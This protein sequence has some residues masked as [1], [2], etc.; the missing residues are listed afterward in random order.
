MK[1]NYVNKTFSALLFMGLIFTT[2][3]RA[4]TLGVG[5]IA[6]DWTLST[7]AGE[8]VNYY[9]DSEERV[10]VILFWATW[11][12]YCRSLMPHLKIL[13]ELYRSK[14]V[15][16]Y[17]LNFREDSD[18]VA[19]FEQNK[20]RFKLMLTADLVAED[21]GVKG[22]PWLL[23]IDKNKKVIYKRPAGITDIIVSQNVKYAIK[24]ALTK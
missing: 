6:P 23:V 10:S 15:E 1:D 9:N 5:D 16:F 12:P 3:P 19:Y 18:P 13:H 20:F 11:C 14:Q 2:N 4:A 7:P 21:Y 24:K 22:T 17:A 8:T